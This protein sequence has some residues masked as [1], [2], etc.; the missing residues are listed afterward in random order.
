MDNIRR[1]SER[2][3]WGLSPWRGIWNHWEIGHVWISIII[4]NIKYEKTRCSHIDG[5]DLEKPGHMSQVEPRYSFTSCQPPTSS[6]QLTHY[7]RACWVRGD[8]LVAPSRTY[9][10]KPSWVR[11]MSLFKLD[12]GLLSSHVRTKTLV[13]GQLE[14]TSRYHIKSHSLGA[15][16]CCVWVSVH[17][18]MQKRMLTCML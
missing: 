2:T 5:V 8:N 16:W 14:I 1:Y 7:V 6:V 15:P 17:V 4:H 13:S 3:Q 12:K 9:M 11:R 10:E 18:G